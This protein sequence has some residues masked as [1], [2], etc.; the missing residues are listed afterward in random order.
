M[1]NKNIFKNTKPIELRAIPAKF[2][3]PHSVAFFFHDE[4]SSLIVELER[5]ESLMVHFDL[6]SEEEREE[7]QQLRGEELWKWLKDNGYDDIIYDLTYRQLTAAVITDAAHFICESLLSCGKGKTTVAYSLLRKPF[8]ENLLVLEWMLAKPVDFLNNFNGETTKGYVL[9]NLSKEK[10]LEIMK[11]CTDL[12]QAKGIDE[13]LLWNIRYDKN[14][15]RGLEALWT[16]ATH[17][18]TSYR[19]VS[20]TE[21]G[22]LNFVFSNASAIDDQLSHYYSIVPLILY[23]F[24][25]VAEA[26]SSR[27][28]EWNEELRSMQLLLRHLAFIRYSEFSSFSPILQEDNN[29]IWAELEEIL[30]PCLNCKSKFHIT[31]SDVDKL[32]LTGCVEC[33]KCGEEN[34]IWDILLG[35]SNNNNGI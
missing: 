10:R 8:K 11:E 17:L 26:V 19:K 33:T 6:E 13:Q 32:W 24:V 16:K 35:N 15:H 3:L 29:N 27:F 28:I 14:L 23:Y 1:T 30:F 9:N 22:N 21:P 2:D 31:K 7:M 34:N 20:A 4:L 18:I 5:T 12:I 25:N